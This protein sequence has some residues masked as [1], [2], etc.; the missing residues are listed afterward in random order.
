LHV[1]VGTLAQQQLD[2]LVVAFKRCRIERVAVLAALPVD[3]GAL[4]Q[5]QLDDLV[6]ASR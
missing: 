5:Q 4:T 3:V 6:V 2:D 1:N